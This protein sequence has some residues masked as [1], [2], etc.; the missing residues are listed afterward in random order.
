MAVLSKSGCNLGTC[1]G[2]A[3]GKGGLKL[4]LRGQTPETDYLTLTRETGARRITLLDPEASLL[5][6]KPLMQI[7]HEG[8][9]RLERGSAAHKILRDWIAGGLPQEDSTTPSLISLNVSPP[10]ATV[11][12]PETS[13]SLKVTA[14]FD[15]GSTRDV[16]AL[17][18]YDP[19][20]TSVTV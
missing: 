3:N 12:A 15:D 1:H 10:N 11:S 9:R 4:S 16:T 20:M 8:G 18:V 6:Q 14:T 2:N 5:L 19:S 13:A 7:P 17:A